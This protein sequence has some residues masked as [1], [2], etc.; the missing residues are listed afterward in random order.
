MLGNKTSEQEQKQDGTQSITTSVEYDNVSNK[1]KEVDG[2]GNATTYTYD[3]NNNVKTEKNPKNQTTTYE[4]D[5]NGNKTKEIDYLG[6]E[7]KYVYDKLDRVIQKIDEY[8]NVIEKLEY[9]DSGRQIKSI[10]VNNNN[11]EFTYD[12]NDNVIS[13]KDQEGNTEYFEYDGLKNKTKYIDKNGNVTIYTYTNKNKVKKVTNALNEITEYTYDNAGNILTQKDGKNNITQY[14]YDLNGNEIKKLDQVLNEEEKTYYKNGLIATFISNNSD[15]FVYEYD[16]HGRLT[17]ETVGQEETTYEYDNNDNKTKIGNITK[18][19]DELDRIL[20][21]TENSQ[22]ITYAYD[23][24]NKKKVT[25]DPKGNVKTEEYDKINRLVKVTT[26][27]DVTEYV[28]NVDG[29]VQKQTNPNTESNYEY[30]TDNKVKRLTTKDKSGN[31][32]EENY[33]EYDSN[34]NVSKDNEKA[35]TYDA[36]NRIH[37]A[38]ENAKTTTYT[39]D[40]AG[41]ILTK[42][43]QDG[44]NLKTVSYV[45]NAKNQLLITSTVDN[46]TNTQTQYQYADNGNQITETTG[47][48]VITNTYNA[49]N[50]LT[51]VEK[52][53][54][55]STY[56]YNA[57]G[58]RIQKTINNTT[59]KFVYDKDDIILELDN[60]NTQV[61]TNTYGLTLIKRNATTKGYYIYNAHGDV[62]K[63][64]DENNNILNTYKYDEFGSIETETGTF[65]NPYRYAGYY[66]DKETKTYYLQARYYNPQIQRFI[67]EDTYRGE[68]E[69]PLSLNLYTY[70]VNNPMIYVDPTGHFFEEIGVLAKLAGKRLAATMLATPEIILNTVVSTAGLAWNLGET[71]GSEIGFIGNEIGYKAGLINEN[72]YLNNREFCLGVMS[73]NLEMYK[74]MPKNMVFGIIDNFKTTFN[75]D[76]I[77]NYLDPN[78]SYDEIKDYNKSLIQ[79]SLTIYGGVKLGKLGYNKISGIAS[80]SSIST[81]NNTTYELNVP[82]NTTQY[83]LSKSSNRISYN[84]NGLNRNMVWK[85]GDINKRGYVKKWGNL[86]TLQD[87]FGRHGKDFNS[88]SINDYINKSQKFYKSKNNYQVKIDQD[89][90]IRIY[91]PVNNTFGSYNPD[92]TTRTFF[93]PTSKNYWNNQTGNLK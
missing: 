57:E 34:N 86:D 11:I 30:Y 17:K 47:T 56:G 42:I 38:I 50:E 35:Y 84:E 46:T 89:G 4:Y 92:G 54:D 69:D 7:K 61:A 26:G 70:V 88:N 3:A 29:S 19:Y 48:D 23:D 16:I 22:T 91:D 25:T 21:N 15:T 66:Y 37:T 63:I 41:N 51:Q 28:Y 43:T 65:D 5:L 85:L 72:I 44:L 2:K 64:L 93:K 87:H 58:K 13:K 6:N 40:A 9:D 83:T 78:A 49:R 67:S 18:T 1:T 62:L 71:L 75:K 12:G 60:Q 45:Y 52:G 79:T 76:N 81:I 74:Q 80:N 20:T 27:T 10:D 8:N 36:L 82:S 55:I 14:Q 39:Y 68:L 90:V 33:Y 59:T 32:I 53:Q 73:N 24:Q 77:L 31:I